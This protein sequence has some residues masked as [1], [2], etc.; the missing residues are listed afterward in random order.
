LTQV[1]NKKTLKKYQDRPPPFP[2][3]SPC[4]VLGWCGGAIPPP[5]PQAWGGGILDPAAA[6][7]SKIPND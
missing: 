1:N 7:P 4:Y 6:A 3:L 5:P 2:L